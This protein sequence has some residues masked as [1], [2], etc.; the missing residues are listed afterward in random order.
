MTPR[1]RVWRWWR[2]VAASLLVLTMMTRFSPVAI[3]T[4]SVVVV[5]TDGAGTPLA[6]VAVGIF[7]AVEVVV[8]GAETGPP[9]GDR[10]GEALPDDGTGV[11]DVVLEPGE[12]P[13]VDPVV[14]GADGSA[15]FGTVPE[16]VPLFVVQTALPAG[17]EDATGPVALTITAAGA[18]VPVEVAL[19]AQVSVGVVEAIVASA[20][21]GAPIPGTTIAVY[22]L[23][24]PASGQRG[25]FVV[26]ATTGAAGITQFELPVGSYIVAL[27]GAPAGFLAPG[28]AADQRVT[29]AMATSGQRDYHALFFEMQP[30]E[31]APPIP[32]TDLTVPVDTATAPEVAPAESKSTAAS[33]V[34]AEPTV[35]VETPAA[36]EGAASTP[37]GSVTLTITGLVCADA[38]QFNRTAYYRVTTEAPYDPAMGEPIEGC[39][40]AA[41]DEVT[42]RV[43]DPGGDDLFDDE[44]VASAAIG[45]DGRAIMTVPVEAAE[46]WLFV[47]QEDLEALSDP[48]RVV[49]GERVSLVAVNYVLPSFGNLVVRSQDEETAAVVAGGCYTL[50]SVDGSV[51][52]FETCD[53][54]DDSTDGRTRF[55]DVPNG[56]YTVRQTAAAPGYAPAADRTVEV[57]G[58]S[59]ETS[60][61]VDALG[62]I[63]IWAVTC[64]GGEGVP[65]LV[66]G[67]PIRRA[68]N[69]DGT[70]VNPVASTPVADGCAG[71]AAELVI[72]PA[73]S[74]GAQAEM[75][76]RTGEDGR[77]VAV[78]M[79]PVA[80]PGEPHRVELPDGSLVAEVDVVPGAITIVTLILPPAEAA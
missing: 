35:P 75:T 3:A 37:A 4:G 38:F 49:P 68:A 18:A 61:G 17:Y 77:A 39:R 74:S 30:G 79:V 34:P 36:S 33:T 45:T 47:S 9:A 43:T 66:V 14:T 50:V 78:P 54:A 16:E 55:L 26:E 28:P 1:S 72:V 71:V 80:A 44:V 10:A 46:R 31:P 52:P 64:D 76:V 58:R 41:A 56:A 2:I 67:D 5:V 22:T 12:T 20:T 60:V 7:G 29:V 19:V 24:D 27:T 48:F 69:G 32:T 73:E 25:T 70:G 53:V 63:E 59:V 65:E 40:L 23:P 15:T 6:G 11:Q 62:A 51:E 13:V 57:A 8:D 42:Y 21:D